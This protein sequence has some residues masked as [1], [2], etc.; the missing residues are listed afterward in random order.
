MERAACGGLPWDLF[1]LDD[2]DEHPRSYYHKEQ[3][4]PGLSVCRGCPVILEC[5]EEAIKDRSLD[6]G[7]RGGMT[8]IQRRAER[9]RRK[10]L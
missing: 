9:R 3:F 2:L 6:V 4:L 8:T 5:R 1:F 7:I 10:R